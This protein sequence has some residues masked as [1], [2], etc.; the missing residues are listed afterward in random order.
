MHCLFLR[1]LSRLRHL[2]EFEMV[3]KCLILFFSVVFAFLFSVTCF[4]GYEN[5]DQYA[6]EFDFDEM[7]DSVDDETVG[8]LNEIGIDEISYEAL[9]SVNLRK[10]SDVLFDLFKKS[11]TE[12]FSFLV[13]AMSIVLV[14]YVLTV[15]VSS[16]E[17]VATIGSAVLVLCAAVPVA[18]A[19]TNAFSVLEATG[20]FTTVFT[21]IFCALISSS[22]NIAL[23]TSYA[24]LAV[25]SNAAFS[26]LLSCFS[27][28]AVSAM[29]SLSF[30]SCFDVYKFSSK[31]SSTI[32][33][34]YISFLGFVATFF[35]GIVTLKGV[36]GAGADSL[37][38]RGVK[39]VVGRTVPIVGGTVSDTY[40]ALVSSLTLIRSTVG[41]FGIA[42]VILTVLP[43]LFQ[44][45]SWVLV[46]NIVIMLSEFLGSEGVFGMLSVL[47]DALILLVATIIFSAV[48]FV[49]SVGIII[50]IKGV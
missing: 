23:G 38:A 17:I 49:V 12:P 33:K 31:L 47:K 35:S 25:F 21:G 4:G 32:K 2:F 26:G 7:V 20:A 37:T 6:E 9:F 42:T 1:Q 15:F 5:I 43:T 36:L 8:I 34:I 18:G 45:L 10:I 40:S 27:K 14:T 28:P 22:G 24:S 39:F 29:C 48:I 11:F 50:F 41:V 19:V 44:L 30:L 16:K 46:L 13:T 3:K